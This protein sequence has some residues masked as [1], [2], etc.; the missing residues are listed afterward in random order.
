MLFIG[1]R[2]VDELLNSDTY[3]VECAHINAMEVVY[4]YG[5]FYD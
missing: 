2:L 3:C 1:R 4:L 5:L